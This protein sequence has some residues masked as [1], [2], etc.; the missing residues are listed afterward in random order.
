MA[1]TDF[2]MGDLRKV[3]S[4]ALETQQ[5]LVENQ[6]LREALKDRGPTGRLIGRGPAIL[7]VLHL[8]SQ[9]APLKSTVLIEGE[10]GVGKHIDVSAGACGMVSTG[11][12]RFNGGLTMDND[13]ISTRVLC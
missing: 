9:V 3:V 7:K 6:R 11:R 10:S 8:I 1:T 13:D 12:H 4:K 5:L 2:R